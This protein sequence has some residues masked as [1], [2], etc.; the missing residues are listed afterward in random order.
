[1]SFGPWIGNAMGVST[2]TAARRRTLSDFSGDTIETAPGT[3]TMPLVASTTSVGKALDAIHANDLAG[4]RAALATFAI[5]KEPRAAYAAAWCWHWLGEDSIAYP[6]ALRALGVW[7]DA[8]TRQAVEHDVLRMAAWEGT[9]PD[10]VLEDLGTKVDDRVRLALAQAYQ[11]VGKSDLAFQ[12]LSKIKTTADWVIR[13]QSLQMLAY[14]A[15]FDGDL[16]SAVEHIEVAVRAIPAGK[17]PPVSMGKTCGDAPPLTSTA[18]AT[19]EASALAALGVLTHALAAESYRTYGKVY[20]NRYALTSRRLYALL[21][22]RFEMPRDQIDECSRQL[23]AMAAASHGQV[24]RVDKRG[25]RGPVQ[26]QVPALEVCYQRELDTDPTFT[27]SV[28]IRFELSTSGQVSSIETFPSP[29]TAATQ[30]LADCTKSAMNH[31][32]LPRQM[33]TSPSIISYPLR[34]IRAT[35]SP[36]PAADDAE[37]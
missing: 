5:T 19:D 11:A 37:N 28:D 18:V 13:I 1:M 6:A 30:R 22:E 7:Q 33:S 32:G 36:S 27:G 34:F 2:I 14:R 10:K 26:R 3:P 24:G 31:L 35:G 21:G 16:T 17:M 29:V 20:D 15:Y 8:A 25:F 12:T 4:A 9:E 23:D